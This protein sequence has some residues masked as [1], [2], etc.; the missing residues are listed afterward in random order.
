MTVYQTNFISLCSK[1]LSSS[2]SFTY[3]RSSCWWLV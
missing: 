2:V 1:E 3:F